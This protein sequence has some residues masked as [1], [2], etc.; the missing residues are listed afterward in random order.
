[1]VERAAHNMVAHTGE[2]LH[3]AA[4]HEHDRVLLEV[5]ALTGDVGD[6]LEAVRQADLGDFPQRRVRLLGGRGVHAGA[7]ATT[8]RIGLQRRRFLFLEN[9][10][11][12]PTDELVDR[13]HVRL[14]EFERDSP[15]DALPPDRV[16]GGDREKYASDRG[17]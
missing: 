15:V 17:N 8:K 4:A 10:A 14:R 2:I 11:A 3:T 16:S 1:S 13:W 7:N 9:V 5:V 6:D 12:A